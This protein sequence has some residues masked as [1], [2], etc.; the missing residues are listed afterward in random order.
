MNHLSP[1]Q[2]SNW[3]IGERTA[4]SARHARECPQCGAELERMEKALSHFRDSGR[5]WGDYW[6]T[7]T[8]HEPRC[9]KERSL[10]S[11]G[12]RLA[13]ALA[14]CLLLA[15]LLIHSPV[16]PHL[17]QEPFVQIPYVAPPAPYERTEV[18]RMDVPVVTLMAAG[19]DV[20]VPAVGGTV[21]ADVLMGQDGRALAVRLVP[22]SVS[23]LARRLNP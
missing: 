7:Q 23:D 10:Q 15:I 18:M 3:M 14:A 11:N 5:R 8:R 16:P 1:E 4:E 6:Y 17:K 22:D 13:G 12:F 20:H 2:I 19:L 21:R 9:G